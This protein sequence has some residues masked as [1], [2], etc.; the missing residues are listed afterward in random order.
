MHKNEVRRNAK[1]LRE[2]QK[3]KKEARP[4]VDA[5]PKET[6]FPVSKLL[7]CG[8]DWKLR[9]EKL[10]E[11]PPAPKQKASIVW[12]RAGIEA[13]QEILESW[14]DGCFLDE[15]ET[16]RNLR[17]GME[18][19]RSHWYAFEMNGCSVDLVVG[20]GWAKHTHPQPEIIIKTIFEQHLTLCSANH[21]GEQA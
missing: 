15:E 20:N 6:M 11:Q 14:A 21:E 10:A 1:K 8:L 19:T 18:I 4:L 13:V 12:T 7:K 5:L 2:L 9:K 17:E 16:H 3:R